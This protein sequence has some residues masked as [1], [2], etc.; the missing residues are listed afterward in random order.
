MEEEMVTQPHMRG[1]EPFP[2]IQLTPNNE[3]S[4]DEPDMFTSVCFPYK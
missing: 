3:I 4:E 2:Q 1:V